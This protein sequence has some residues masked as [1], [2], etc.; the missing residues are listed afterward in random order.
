MSLRTE[1]DIDDFEIVDYIQRRPALITKALTELAKPDVRRSPGLP[2]HNRFAAA[3]RAIGGTA[4]E[5][6]DNVYAGAA[7]WAEAFRDFDCIDKD[8]ALAELMRTCP[9][10]VMEWMAVNA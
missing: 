6:V 4:T 1:V 7:E 2:D 10:D 8:R 5:Q 9:T 3:L